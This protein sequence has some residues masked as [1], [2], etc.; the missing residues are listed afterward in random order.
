MERQFAASL[1]AARRKEYSQE[2]SFSVWHPDILH[3]HGMLQEPT[4]FSL[5]IV[6]P[7]DYSAFIREYLLQV[8]DGERLHLRGAG[9]IGERPHGVHVIVLGEDFRE[10]R[11]ASR[12]QVD[13]ACGQ[14][15]G[16]KELIK[17]ADD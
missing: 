4:T 15:A 5:L 3:L 9:F 10:F 11:S 6:E 2:R 13:Y 17:I 14:I 12:H 7:V 16:V 8:A 1:A